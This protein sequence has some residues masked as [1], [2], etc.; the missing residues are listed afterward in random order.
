MA[1]IRLAFLGVLIVLGLMFLVGAL[2]GTEFRGG[3]PFPAADS[4]GMGPALPSPPVSTDWFL[5]F[6]R[7]FIFVGVIF[8]AFGL[9]FSK[10]FR[11]RF[12]YLLFALGILALLFHYLPLRLEI[13]ERLEAPPPSSPSGDTAGQ[14]E[15]VPQAPKWAPYLAALVV[16]F[17]L[18]IVFGLRLSAALE[19][20]RKRKAIREVVQ[21]AF[22]ELRSGAPV[23]DVVLRCWMRMVEILSKKSGTKDRPS[24][25]AREFAENLR[26]LGFQ[27]EAIEI[28]T[29]L[30]EEVRYG[31]KESE[32]RRAKA[33]AA[34]A[35]LEQAYS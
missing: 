18:A 20:R 21:E 26:K 3:K 29:E 31:R 15:P 11:K 7:F 30:F 19:R 28:L 2:R 12:L 4:G 6:F 22:D 16:A 5:D 14:V 10:R 24:L 35:A 33:L 34:L 8:V 23:Y 17:V 1:R 25:T 32:P 9:I 27:H 13:P